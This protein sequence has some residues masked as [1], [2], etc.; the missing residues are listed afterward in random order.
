VPGAYLK[1]YGWPEDDETEQHRYHALLTAL[2]D[3]TGRVLDTL[4][5]TG[6][7][8]NT[9]V[10]FISDMGAILRP[11][12][13]LGVASNAPFRDGAPSLYEGG[14][15]VPAI[16]RWPG[17][18]KPGTLCREMLSQ[19]DVLPLLLAASGGK[20]QQGRIL[21]G[22]DPLP[23]LT[24][25]ARS[26]HE[27]LVFTYRTGSALREGTLK[28]IRSTPTQPWELYDLAADPG[29]TTNLASQR[30]ADVARLDAAYQAWLADVRRDASEPAPRP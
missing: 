15:R 13:G 5:A 14:I 27:R 28:L 22:R 4:D 25:V 12:H 23:A 9:L 11:T 18:I 30:T 26:P 21:D 16:F 6:L 8:D 3:A 24:G 20:P 29:E 10:M 2:D 1:R 19:L 7:R 17:K